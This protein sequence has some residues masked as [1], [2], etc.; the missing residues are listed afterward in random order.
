ME[1][2]LIVVIVLLIGYTFFLQ[3]NKTDLKSKNKKEKESKT[4]K[5]PK[6]ETSITNEYPYGRKYLLTKT[7]YNFYMQLKKVCDTYSYII[8]P[9]VRLEDFI[10]VI[11]TDNK[12]KY[13]NH[14]K[15]R[16]VD[17]LICDN[18]LNIILAIELDD[19]YHDS[20]KAKKSDDFKNKLYE[21]IE[22]KLCRIKTSSSYSQ[23]L[24]N[25]FKDLECKSV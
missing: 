23:K 7:E 21:K 6:T 12:Q 17:F 18:K 24:E 15:S 10:K 2:I 16:H 14:I 4:E 8:C 11:D 25:I 13:R 22:I 1:I 5:E 20:V 9:K 19:K 3:R